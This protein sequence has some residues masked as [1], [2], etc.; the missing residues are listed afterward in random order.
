MVWA[1][2]R[3]EVPESEPIAHLV[4]IGLADHANDD[5]TEARPSVATLAKYARCS[6]RT[7][8]NKLRALE[9]AG[10]IR[11]GDQQTVAHIRQDRRPVVYDL[12]MH[13][14]REVHDMQAAEPVDKPANGLHDVHPV[15]VNGVHGGASRG[16]Q[17]GTHGV[18][19]CADRTV[20]EPSKNHPRGGS[21]SPNSPTPVDNS[22]P[23][24]LNDGNEERARL[25]RC[26]RHQADEFP[27]PCGQC[28]EARLG[29]ERLAAAVSEAAASPEAL[30]PRC[31]FHGW[32]YAATCRE[33][34]G[35]HKGGM[36]SPF[37]RRECRF[38]AHAFEGEV[39]F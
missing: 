8:H 5:G 4:L 17:P 30:G 24:P 39:A 20:L 29:A 27:P 18:N 1:L 38:C 13:A 7:V 6:P 21:S 14:G 26:P 22:A 25:D 3:A 19:V 15:K 10:L 32:E 16:E 11:R 34:A 9:A 28:K 35:E 37:P 12:V 2:K 36:H 33:C 31:G 23:L